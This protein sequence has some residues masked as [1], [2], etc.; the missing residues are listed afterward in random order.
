MFPAAGGGPDASAVGSGECTAGGVTAGGRAGEREGEGKREREEEKEGSGGRGREREKGMD[1]EETGGRSFFSARPLCPPAALSR[2]R[3][4]VR[5]G[6]S[7]R[8]GRGESGTRRRAAVPAGAAWPCPRAGADA[9]ECPGGLF[10]GVKGGHG[11]ARPS[12]GPP[13]LADVPS[14]VAVL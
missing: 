5:E 1:G 6:A 12:R 14:C 2:H 7:G 8:L 3:A 10:A 9:A 11:A 13:L 4:R